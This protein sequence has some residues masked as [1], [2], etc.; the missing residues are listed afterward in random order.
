MTYCILLCFDSSCLAVHHATVM[1]G[2]PSVF[3]SVCLS[4]QPHFGN[5]K[6]IVYFCHTSGSKGQQ[7][8]GSM[9]PIIATGGLPLS[10]WN[11]FS[12]EFNKLAQIRNGFGS[13]THPTAELNAV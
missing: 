5:L 10:V 6:F 3:H 8:V 7:S 9:Q 11:L 12:V 4:G 13:S 2:V 1:A